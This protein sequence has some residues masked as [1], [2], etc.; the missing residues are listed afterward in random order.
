[1]RDSKWLRVL[2]AASL[3][4]MSACSSAEPVPSEEGVGKS[5]QAL[6]G[7]CGFGTAALANVGFPC[8]PDGTAGPASEC[9]YVCKLQAST[10]PGG[11]TVQCVK[12]GS[13]TENDGKLC[14]S[15]RGTD[16]TKQ[17][18]GS[19]CVALNAPD[20][21][22]CNPSTTFGGAPCQGE[23]IKGA[24]TAL[25]N[26]ARC[27]D[28]AGNCK[29]DTCSPTSA[30]TC[31]SYPVPKGVACNDGSACTG[32]DACDGTGKCTGTAKVCPSSGSPCLVNACVASTGACVASPAPGATCTLTTDKC[33]AGVCDSTGACAKGA[34]LSCDDG[35]ACTV[36]A[37]DATTGCTHTAKSCPPPS[38]ACTVA[39]C[40]KTSGACGFVSKSCDDGNPC[41]A[42]ACDKIAG[43]THTPIPGCTYTPDSG[44][45]AD[46]GTPP[47]DSGTVVTDSGTVTTD[48]G[49]VIEDSGTTPE[50]TGTI[51]EDTGTVTEDSGTT[52]TDSGT[53]TDDAG[54]EAGTGSEETVEAGGCGCRTTGSAGSTGS[55]A[56]ALGAVA[57]VAVR[58]RRGR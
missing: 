12:V 22:A 49:T 6:T 19:L 45:P 53:P 52:P 28:T 40:D 23:C 30:R 33:Y 14:G 18:K 25:P 58:R 37:C 51:E 13:A 55:F 42:D 41:T 38:D 56:L 57:L 7:G 34:A 46:T 10:G 1:M 11:Y 43:C 3:L 9:D 21:T 17:C 31:T 48:S 36:D 47:T 32:G 29:L 8:D 44:V 24:C 2:A 39:T 16:C 35:D 26:S 54:D 27:T 5:E 15:A 20:G 4:A 50:D